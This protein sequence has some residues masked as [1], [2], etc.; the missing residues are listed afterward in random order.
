[1]SPTSLSLSPLSPLSPSASI[2]HFLVLA[3]IHAVT[4]VKCLTT[5]YQL[6]PVASIHAEWWIV[7]E[8]GY[9]NVYQWCEVFY[10]SCVS[11]WNFTND[12][13]MY[14]AF[15]VLKTRLV[16][17]SVRMLGWMIG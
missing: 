13:C 5:L 2:R 12:C 3:S 6:V 7:L 11:L 9:Q 4:H 8:I 14:E 17:S 10:R 1:V 15:F 16:Y